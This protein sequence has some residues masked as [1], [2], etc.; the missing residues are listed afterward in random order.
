MGFKMSR[1]EG[2]YFLGPEP[3]LGEGLSL[4]LVRMRQDIGHCFTY[5]MAHSFSEAEE[6]AVDASG[7]ALADSVELMAGPSNCGTQV[8]A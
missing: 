6:K 3:Y 7:F 8:V 4:F 5:V 2:L 1:P